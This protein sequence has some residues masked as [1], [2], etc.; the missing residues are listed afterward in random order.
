MSKVDV[1]VVGAGCAG[2]VAACTLKTKGYNVLLLDEHN[3]IG[4]LSSSITK[5][6]FEFEPLFHALYYNNPKGTLF[7][8]DELFNILGV[9]VYLR[10]DEEVNKE[11][12]KYTTKEAEEKALKEAA[13][14]IELTLDSNERIISQKV[15]QKTINFYKFAT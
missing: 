1:I 6:R 3:S 5:G 11:N 15:L 4:G 8:L 14:K 9:K 13:K 12:H 2:V 7:S 10:K